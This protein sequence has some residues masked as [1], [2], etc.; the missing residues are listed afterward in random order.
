M[1][2]IFQSRV[3]VFCCLGVLLLAVGLQAAEKPPGDTV[4]YHME[5]KNR[6]HVAQ[7]RRL[8]KDPAERAKYKTMT[9]AE[10]ENKGLLLCSKCPGSD[11]PGKEK[12]G[13]KKLDSWVNPPRDEARQAHPKSLFIQ[14]LT[15]RIETERAVRVLGEAAPVQ[16]ARR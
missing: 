9:L 7:C 16:E 12:D 14:Q 3:A 13:E 8:P 6:V 4:V 11:T 5:G 10:A 1:A 15:D 2:M